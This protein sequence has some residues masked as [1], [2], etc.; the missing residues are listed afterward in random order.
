VGGSS[1]FGRKDGAPPLNFDPVRPMPGGSTRGKWL[2]L[3]HYRRPHAASITTSVNPHGITALFCCAQHRCVRMGANDKER[4][5]PSKQ[6][7]AECDQ[8]QLVGL[9]GS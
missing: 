2:K 1:F 8:K 9:P 4:Y 5:F 3:L 7:L 6:L